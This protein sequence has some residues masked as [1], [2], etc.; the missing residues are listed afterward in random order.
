ME[1]INNNLVILE[2]LKRLEP[3]DLVSFGQLNHEFQEL[4][5]K[6]EIWDALLKRDFPADYDQKPKTLTYQQYYIETYQ[7]KIQLEQE[8]PLMTKPDDM[9]WRIFQTRT[10]RAFRLDLNIEDLNLLPANSVEEVCELNQMTEE[11]LADLMTKYLVGSH[12]DHLL[13]R[14]DVVWLNQLDY[15][16]DGRFFWDGHQVI[17]QDYDTDDYGM[18]PSIFLIP[19]EFNPMHFQS[20]EKHNNFI[21]F[22]LAK[23]QL[24]ISQTLKGGNLFG[25]ACVFATCHDHGRLYYVIFRDEEEDEDDPKKTLK[26]VKKF[27][28]KTSPAVVAD[29]EDR[30]GEI[31]SDHA[32]DDVIFIYI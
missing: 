30:S 24:E 26:K 22:D 20:V 3:K 14:G 9:S 18:V 5:K 7:L 17:L 2:I 13:F 21:W 15:R 19:T 1:Q 6:D 4:L 10:E 27:L 16:N 25:H 11:E 8:H 32:V 28:K 31:I 23:H 29:W 12:Q